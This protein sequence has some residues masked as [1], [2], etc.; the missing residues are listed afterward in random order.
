VNYTYDGDDKRVE[1][2]GAKLYWY[3][4]MS[5]ALEETNTSGALTNDQ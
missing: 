4:M 3:G 5:D 2:S 1:K